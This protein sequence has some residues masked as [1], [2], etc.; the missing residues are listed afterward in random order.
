MSAELLPC[1]FCG[2]VPTMIRETDG[3]KWGAVVCC[4]TG[5]EVRTFYKSVE[6]WRNEAIAAWNCRAELSENPGELK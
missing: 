4:I 3:Y 5:P 6:H 2:Q 1:P